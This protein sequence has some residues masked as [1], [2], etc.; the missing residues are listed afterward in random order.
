MKTPVDL[1][2]DEYQ[3]GG[4][5]SSA[6][7]GP[8]GAVV[9]AV[10]RLKKEGCRL[11][12]AVDVGSG[13]GRNSLYLAEQGLEVTALDFTPAAIAVLKKEVARHEAGKRIR[14]LVYDVTEPWPVGRNDIDL[15]ADAFCFKHIT[16]DIA[17]LAYKQNMLAVLGLRGH[18][19]IS[20]SSIGDGY[21]G[22]Y[23]SPEK[24]AG[25]SEDAV[26]EIVIDPVN[27]IESV[28]YSRER[29]LEFFAPELELHA[30]VKHNKPS[31]MHGQ[32][33]E[34]ETYALLFRRKPQ[35]FAG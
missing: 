8:S 6:R 20:F 1:W 24:R 11:R 18:Y 21:Y 16:P 30:E 23:R 17:R 32:T 4:I 29:V 35:Y 31:V 5:P 15:V 2:T 22:R 26:E 25:D 28:L 12:T 13:K 33:Y 3:T 34:R 10:E 27:G 19:L 9:W 14:P 7:T